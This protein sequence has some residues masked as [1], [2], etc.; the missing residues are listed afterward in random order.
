MRNFGTCSFLLLSA[1][2]ADQMPKN[3]S[4]P[5]PAS[6]ASRDCP[7]DLSANRLPGG[8]VL[9]VGAGGSPSRPAM[10]VTFR[11]ASSS[12]TA[13]IAGAK[14]TLH[15]RAGGGV[16]PAGG[17]LAQEATEVFFVSPTAEAGRVFRSTLHVG[18]LTA[19]SFV[20]INEL[21]YADGTRWHASEGSACRVA[22]S[23]YMLTAATR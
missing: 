15:G 22:P 20:E 6:P 3:T 2:L 12:S 4:A 19:V 5:L 8:D 7:V 1:T 17:R 16:E 11:P 14:I 9:R 13:A 21:T 10:K 18:R 23:G